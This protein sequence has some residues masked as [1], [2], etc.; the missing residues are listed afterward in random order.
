MTEVSIVITEP[1]HPL[2]VGG[3]EWRHDPAEAE[4][5][6]R[7]LRSKFCLTRLWHGVAVPEELTE[8]D[9]IT[10]WVDGI[11]WDASIEEQE[12]LL[13]KPAREH[14]RSYLAEGAVTG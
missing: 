12:E 7:S 6:F 3:F 9:A 10:D 4:T 8:P 13:G 14:G 1:T 5:E 2:S 11:Y